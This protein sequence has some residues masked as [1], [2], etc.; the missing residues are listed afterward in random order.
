MSSWKQLFFEMFFSVD[1]LGPNE[2]IS[3]FGQKTYNGPQGFFKFFVQKMR[4]F[5]W[6]LR[7]RQK[8]TFQKQLFS[9]WQKFLVNFF[10]SSS[11]TNIG[12]Q[13]MR[14]HKIFWQLLWKLWEHFFKDLRGRWKHKVWKKRQS[15]QRK[16][17]FWSFFWVYQT[18]QMSGRKLTRFH[19][20]F[21]NLLCKW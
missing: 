21:S 6:D 16:K 2:K 4:S 9:R 10:L 3:S 5:H 18:R 19:R 20:V 13:F 1:L 11:L 17:K 8:Q 12:E 14:I 7:G 15:L